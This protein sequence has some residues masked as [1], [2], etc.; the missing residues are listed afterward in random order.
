M[1]EDHHEYIK[2]KV[3]NEEVVPFVHRYHSEDEKKKNIN[4]NININKECRPYQFL[5]QLNKQAVEN[6]L[7]FEPKPMFEKEINYFEVSKNKNKN[8]NMDL[9]LDIP[10]IRKTGKKPEP[11]W[12]EK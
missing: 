3:L 12:L 5:T 9:D 1:K 4:I 10:L 6:W 7:N 2:R 11:K 8:T